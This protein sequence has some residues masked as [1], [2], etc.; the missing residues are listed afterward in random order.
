MKRIDVIVAV[1][2]EEASLPA[3]L[4]RMDALDLPPGVE[5]SLRFVED[6]SRDGTRPL[7]RRLARERP[8]VGYWMLESGFG[9]GLALSFG[10]ARSTA[11][12][13]IVLD[14]DGSHPPEAIP[15]L[16]R[17]YLDGARVVQCVRR[18]LSGRPAWRGLGALAFHT[19][20]RIVTGVDL[21][22]QNVY[23]R[24]MDRSVIDSFLKVPRY[25]RYVRFPLPTGPG[26]VRFV[27]VDT[28]ERSLGASK[29]GPLR[30]LGLSVDGILTAM[31]TR[32]L[33]FNT[34]IAAL[35]VGALFAAGAWPLALA[36]VVAAA[37]VV[38]RF[39]GLRRPAALA[40]MRV[41]ESAGTGEAM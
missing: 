21:R 27:P 18:S 4:A 28:H 31:E 1:R 35:A 37:A 15:E 30:L 2:D 36:G 22:S 16:V 24:L 12:A 11:D 20:V 29:Y 6:S 9:Q 23:Y 10:L 40:R 13:A 17:G 25:W 5:L 3:F 38:V 33:V 41:A 14:V 39:V 34:G 32:R 7:L 26:A 19:M 8:D